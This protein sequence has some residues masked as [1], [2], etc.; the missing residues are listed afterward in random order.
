MSSPIQILPNLHAYRE[1]LLAAGAPFPLPCVPFSQ[2]GLLAALPAP[3]EGRTGWPWTV[4]TTPT[5]WPQVAPK[6][7]VVTPSFQQGEYLEETIRSVLLQ[8]YPALEYVVFD[9]GSTDSSPAIIERYRPW[10]SFA[11]SRRDR[12]QSHAINLGLSLAHGDLRA[13]LNSDDYYLPGA[14]RRVAAG[15]QI[16]QADIIYGDGLQLDER[17]G[18]RMPAP[19]NLAHGRYVKYPGLLLSHATFWA[20]SRQQ[21]IWEE[22]HCALDYEL[23]IRI[24]PG[25]RLRRVPWPLAVARQH[26]AA[27][28]YNPRMQQQWQADAERNGRAHPEL[29]RPRRWLDFEHCSVQ[30]FVGFWRRRRLLRSLPKVYRECGWPS[31]QHASS[32]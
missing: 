25:A 31:P 17:T 18:Q 29:Y 2:Q 4:E 3:R 10:L 8:N 21:P 11:R 32:S 6:I 5:S 16:S 7:S 24:L 12:G 30:R 13:W 20:A 1:E 22:Q 14:L 27:K 15:W 19:A 23:W 28:T 26:E 9:G